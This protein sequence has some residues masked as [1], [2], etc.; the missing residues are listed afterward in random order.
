MR[1]R[2]LPF[3]FLNVLGPGVG[4]NTPAGSDAAPDVTN[5][6]TVEI[7]GTRLKRA[8]IQTPSRVAQRGMRLPRQE[9]PRFSHSPGFPR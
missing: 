6:P 4:A 3:L 9:T 8:D 1:S 2:L 5:L 7:T